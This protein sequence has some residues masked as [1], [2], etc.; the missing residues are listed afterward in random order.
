MRCASKCRCLGSWQRRRD[1]SFQFCA[2]KQPRSWRRNSANRYWRSAPGH[3]M[4]VRIALPCPQAVENPVDH[5]A[6]L[7][8]VIRRIAELRELATAEVLRDFS[9]LGEQVEQR[10]LL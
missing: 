3:T 6:R 2:R 5:H 9:V 4:P 1:A 8:E 10:A 7:P